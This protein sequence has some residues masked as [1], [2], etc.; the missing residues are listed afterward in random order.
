MT[1]TIKKVLLLFT[2]I[3]ATV[4]SGGSLLQLSESELENIVSTNLSGIGGLLGHLGLLLIIMGFVSWM[5]YNRRSHRSRWGRR[6]FAIGVGY[7]IIS[8]NRSMFWGLVNYVI[9]G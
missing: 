6:L 2:P 5:L 7:T 9:G 3:F 4:R 1:V 8:Y